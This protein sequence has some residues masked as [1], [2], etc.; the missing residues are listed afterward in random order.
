MADEVVSTGAALPELLLRYAEELLTGALS[1]WMEMVSVDAA[2]LIGS[3]SMVPSPV[4]DIGA[5]A[6]VDAGVGAVASSL[7][8]SIEQV[9]GTIAM[10]SMGA[11]G[12]ITGDS[13]VVGARAGGSGSPADSVTSSALL[14]LAVTGAS[15]SELRRTQSEARSIDWLI[16]SKLATMALKSRWRSACHASR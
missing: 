2:P 13:T 6:G 3:P 16:A 9:A 1:T 7:G 4:G 15:N 14:E 5:A 10:V 12:V 11:A 8:T